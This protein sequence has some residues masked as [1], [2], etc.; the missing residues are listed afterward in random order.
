MKSRK[1]LL[2]F[3]VAFAWLL[4]VEPAHAYIGPGA[5][6]AFLS[7]GLVLVGSLFLAIGIL[8]IYP[9]KML[10][11]FLTGKGRI[12]GDT[13]RFVII[14]FDGMDP[15]L[16]Q[17]FMDEGLMPNMKALAEEG[18]FSPLQTSYPSMSP[19]AW[20]SF[21]TG[22]DSS[23]H[24]IFDFITRDPCTYLPILSSTEIN[25]GEKALLK[26]GKNEFFKRPTSSIRLLRKGKPWWK[27]LGEKG[28]FSNNKRYIYYFGIID[29]LTNY[30]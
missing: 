1:L 13:K 30:E 25:S 15:I 24:S 11:R 5:G 22:V 12:K 6:F 27:T 23:R 10:F 17:R 20:S 18:T 26:I 8:A 28:I 29:F 16:A 3:A 19:V 4:G 21:S 9:L 14:G 7:G 2:C